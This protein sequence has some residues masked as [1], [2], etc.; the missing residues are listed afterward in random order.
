[1]EMVQPYSLLS[2]FGLKIVTVAEKKGNFFG[3]IGN[4]T[5]SSNMVHRSF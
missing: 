4:D 5:H 2:E 1:M 3:V